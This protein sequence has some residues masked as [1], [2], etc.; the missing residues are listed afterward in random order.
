MGSLISGGK[1]GRKGLVSNSVVFTF[2]SKGTAG[3]GFGGYFEYDFHHNGEAVVATI[4]AMRDGIST[5]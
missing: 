5:S 4:C 3:G 2:G 1:R